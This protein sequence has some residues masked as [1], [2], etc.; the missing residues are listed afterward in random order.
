[1]NRIDMLA[2]FD[3]ALNTVI[4]IFLSEWDDEQNPAF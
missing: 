4:R 3:A 1:M 2:I